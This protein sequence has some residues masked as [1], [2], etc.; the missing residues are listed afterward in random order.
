M[1]LEDLK[2]KAE[3]LGVTVKDDAT[4]ESLTDEIATKEKELESDVNYWKEQATK[5]ESEAK[6]AFSKRDEFK[7][8]KETLA[9][10]IKDLEGKLSGMVPSTDKENLEKEIKELRKFKKDIDD[11][12]TKKDLEN[13]T[14]VERLRIQM[15]KQEK[16][17]REE[18]DEKLTA[19][20]QAKETTEKDLE[21]IR[22]EAETL[23]LHKL[24]SEI[25]K[26]A[27][28]LNAWSAD[29][30]FSLTKDKFIFDKNLN[31]FIHQIKDEKGKLL[32]EMSVKEYIENFL[33]KEENENLI[34]SK[35]NT[36]SLNTDKD[37]TIHN[38]KPSDL[39]KFNPKD[40][41]IVQ[42]AFVNSMTPEMYI[43][44]VLMPYHEKRKLRLGKK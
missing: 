10:Q 35:V 29:Q 14:E 37:K 28:K 33:G 2:K 18:F 27:S 5:W 12:Q 8:N 16:T 15:E 38:P 3:L 11:E 30:I 17:I 21:N 24:E 6:K 43:K 25:I 23:R 22:N 36:S 34:K 26:E 32:D 1:S 19:L 40:P 13:K 4:E 41:K 9:N 31:K 44:N 7:R 42:D 20:M 39:G